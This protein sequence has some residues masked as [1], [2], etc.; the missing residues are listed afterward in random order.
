[1]NSRAVMLSKNLITHLLM[2]D[3]NGWGFRA[4]FTWTA[5]HV[6]HDGL[7]EACS[8]GRSCMQSP[9]ID[10]ESVDLISIC[11]V[12]LVQPVRR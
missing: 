12:S 6:V 10:M 3:L 11:S 7:L 8:L 1:V 2:Q 5:V 9:R 4:L